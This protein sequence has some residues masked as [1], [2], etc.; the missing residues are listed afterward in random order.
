MSSIDGC[1]SIKYIILGNTGGSSGGSGSGGGC[2]VLRVDL[3]YLDGGRD[4][5]ILRLFCSGS[6]QQLM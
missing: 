1:L 6:S 5:P 2:I 3:E 4:D